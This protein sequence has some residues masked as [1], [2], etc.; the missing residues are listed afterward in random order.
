[1]L[2]QNP[3]VTVPISI[4][5]KLAFEVLNYNYLAGE[6]EPLL[7]KFYIILNFNQ[8][9]TFVNNENKIIYNIEINAFDP[10]S[11]VININLT[12]INVNNKHYLTLLL[13]INF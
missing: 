2:D 12:D 3:N 9:I 13:K 1:M 10:E 8:N 6:W 4:D 5:S 11:T 7:E